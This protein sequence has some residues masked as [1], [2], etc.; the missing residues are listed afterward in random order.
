MKKSYIIA[1]VLVILSGISLAQDSVAIKKSKYPQL[2]GHMFPTMVTFRSSFVNTSFR[3]YI[4]LGQTSKL[5]IPGIKIDDY[6]IFTFEGRLLFASINVH[7]QQRFNDWLAL[8][9]SLNLGARLGSDMSTILVDGVNTMTGGEIGWLIKIFQAKKFILSGS[10]GVRNL[11]GSFI[12]V[13]DYFK[14]IIN[15]NPDPSVVK[16]IPA[17]SAGGGLHFAYAI[18]PTFGMQGSASYAYGESFT[19]GET[20]GYY[21]VGL[22]FDA[23]L[24]PA[25]RVPLGFALGYSISSAPEIIMNYK[26]PTK[27]AIARLSYTGSDDFEL[28]L[29][30]LFY[31][32]NSP[33]FTTTAYIRNAILVFK[34]Y[35]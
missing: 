12:N 31:D 10:L 7:Y 26:G 27:I 18:S 4:G 5:T 14:E 13:T 24:E 21:N 33:N 6:E 3:G 20:D 34:Y 29:Q 19:R 2:N 16:V 11:T 9:L 25:K 1:V 23:D 28:G 17:M 32:L 30:F 8:Y 15:N 35:F 22:G